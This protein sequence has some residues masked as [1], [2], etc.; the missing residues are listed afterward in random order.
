MAVSFL[1]KVDYL[2]Q[3]PT[4]ELRRIMQLA[5]I[6]HF[7]KGQ[8]IFSKADLGNQL[9]IVAAG[10]VKIHIISPGRKQKTLA[11]LAKGDFFG[12]MSLLDGKV[13]SASA[14]AADDSRLLVISK[15]DFKKLIAQDPHFAFVIMRTLAQRLRKAD[16]EVENLLFKNLLGRLAKVL[17]DL[18]AHARP[19]DGGATVPLTLTHQELADLVGTSREP[20]TRALGLL[21][22]RGLVEYGGG[23][24]QVVN[25]EKLRQIV[26]T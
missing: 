5:K 13:R 24:I 10:R 7:R 16:E 23:R 14:T 8:A 22:R 15:N 12:E 25:I 6:A 2:K 4:A 26:G 21:K 1:K 9:F 17:L 20:L 19:A 18:T 3:I 11:Y